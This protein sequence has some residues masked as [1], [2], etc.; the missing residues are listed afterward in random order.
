MDIAIV[1][2]SFQH[3][4]VVYV[5]NKELP[6]LLVRQLYQVDYNK[7]VYL[8]NLLI[9]PCTI[10]A[11]TIGTKNPKTKSKVPWSFCGSPVRL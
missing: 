8:Y 1:S 6:A 9:S 11:E 3:P 4:Y 2:L 5:D 10:I 7:F